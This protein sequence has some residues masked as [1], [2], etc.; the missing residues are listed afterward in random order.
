MGRLEFRDERRK[1]T[2][3]LYS[4]FYGLRNNKTAEDIICKEFSVAEQTY[5]FAT[6]FFGLCAKKSRSHIFRVDAEKIGAGVRKDFHPLARGKQFSL[7]YK[8]CA[9]IQQMGC[10]T[11]D[12]A[13]LAG[14]LELPSTG[15][16]I[17]KQLK[18]VEG[19][20]GKVQIEHSHLSEKEAV[21][22]E[23]KAHK[24]N[25]DLLT[26]SCT[27]EGHEHPPPFLD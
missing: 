15:S 24:E 19:V 22:E 8:L 13:T 7:N 9:A 25:E 1:S 23:I 12:V 4:L 3:E 21:A 6:T 16:S 20:M 18:N 17:A 27:I 11:S 26:H 10:G 2:R 14:F 5:G